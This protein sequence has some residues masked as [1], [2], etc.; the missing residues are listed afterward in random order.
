MNSTDMI[1]EILNKYSKVISVR[2]YDHFPHCKAVLLEIGE[3]P[4]LIRYINFKGLTHRSA[5]K[6]IQ[7]YLK[8]KYDNVKR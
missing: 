7:K 4:C 5:I 1:K 3:S 8:R 6:K 2:W